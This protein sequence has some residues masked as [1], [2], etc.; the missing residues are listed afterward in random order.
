[1]ETLLILSGRESSRV[2]FNA[3]SL[4]KHTKNTIGGT[5]ALVCAAKGNPLPV[6]EWWRNGE[7]VRS[8]DSFQVKVSL[9]S[10]V[11]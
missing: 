3:M 10:L 6:Y 8:T 11:S 5:V 9:R 2:N 7:I 4:H 1:M